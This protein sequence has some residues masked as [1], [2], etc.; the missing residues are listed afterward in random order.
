MSGE[1]LN[2]LDETSILL[3]KLQQ[4]REA[5]EKSYQQTLKSIVVE[6]QRV[7]G[8]DWDHWEEDPDMLRQI[9]PSLQRLERQLIFPRTFHI[10][11]SLLSGDDDDPPTTEGSRPAI[12]V[13]HYSVETCLWP[14]D[15]EYYGIERIA[16]T[17]ENNLDE[18]TLENTL[19]AYGAFLGFSDNASSTHALRHVKGNHLVE[20]IHTFLIEESPGNFCQF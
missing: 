17:C 20:V 4:T 19:E 10:L 7:F 9:D 15:Q 12:E 13:S 1:V 8:E 18:T 6:L 2:L 5:L 11:T 3:N 16:W 14:V